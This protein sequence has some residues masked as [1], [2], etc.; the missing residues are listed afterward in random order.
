MKVYELIKML[1]TICRYGASSDVYL[2]IGNKNIKLHRAVDARQNDE[3]TLV[4]VAE[5]DREYYGE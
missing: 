5:N 4:L 2:R 3:H 1:A